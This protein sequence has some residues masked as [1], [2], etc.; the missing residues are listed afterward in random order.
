M[1]WYN[2]GRIEP[3]KLGEPVVVSSTGKAESFPRYYES[4]ALHVRAVSTWRIENV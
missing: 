2:S 4:H 3:A 1:P